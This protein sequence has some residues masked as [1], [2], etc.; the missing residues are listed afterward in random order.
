MGSGLFA[1]EVFAPLVPT[2]VAGSYIVRD[3]THGVPPPPLAATGFLH[4]V[5][6]YDERRPNM[7]KTDLFG[8]TDP[9]SRGEGARDIH[10][11]IDIGGPVG[12]PIHCFADGAIHSFGYNEQ[13]GDYGYVVVTEH[14]LS[15]RKVWALHGHLNARSIKGKQ[16]CQRVAKGEV[17]CWIGDEEENGGWPPHVH[18]QL[19]LVEPETHDLPGVVSSAQRKDALSKYPD[20]RMVL[21]ALYPGDGP[22]GLDPADSA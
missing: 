3:F 14:E 19:S 18:F 17:L 10:V 11:G 8:S 4:D 21:G 20:P 5:G 22:F 6:R 15:G 16:R 2:L 13:P 9:H 7:Y 1:G 12:M